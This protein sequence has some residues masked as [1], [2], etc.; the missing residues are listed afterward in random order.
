MSEEEK[1]GFIRIDYDEAEELE[2]MEEIIH[3]KDWKR[4]QNDQSMGKDVAMTGD[5]KEIEVKMRRDLDE[6]VMVQFNIDDKGSNSSI[7]DEVE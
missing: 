7:E 5:L 1:E 3:E 6:Q 2:V 4:H